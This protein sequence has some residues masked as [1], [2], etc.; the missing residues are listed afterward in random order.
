MVAILFFWLSGFLAFG[1]RAQSVAEREADCINKH[2]TWSVEECERVAKREMRAARSARA[3][4]AKPAA[5]ATSVPARSEAQPAA[6]RGL[7]MLLVVFVCAGVYLLPAIIGQARHHH[8]R[9]AIW[10][11]NICLGWTLFGWVGSL[12]WASS[13]TPGEPRPS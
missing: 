3:N 4:V 10:A 11:L 2:P 5:V 12:V 6:S 13:A 7:L 9:A 1:A 8:Q